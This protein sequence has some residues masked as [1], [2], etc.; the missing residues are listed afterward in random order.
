MKS[1]RRSVWRSI[2]GLYEFPLSFLW[3][4][5]S[6]I[7]CHISVSPLTAHHWYLLRGE[8]ARQKII[9]PSS[10]SS[11]HLRD[12]LRGLQADRKSLWFLRRGSRWEWS[13][14]GHTGLLQH[15][16]WDHCSHICFLLWLSFKHFDLYHWNWDLRE[17]DTT[18]L[19]GIKGQTA[20]WHCKDILPCFKL[21]QLSKML[22]PLQG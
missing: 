22:C 15:D 4:M 6:Y 18:C 3:K 9:G 17:L 12:V 11:S 10:A 2:T 16:G 1:M 14:G 20:F 5:S 21:S 13:F 7:R 8:K 19:W